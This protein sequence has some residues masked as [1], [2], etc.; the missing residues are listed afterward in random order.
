MTP[1]E[2]Q[3]QHDRQIA[4]IRKLLRV[5]KSLVIDT[6]KDMRELIAV[7]KR[8]EQ[9]LE[10]LIHTMRRGANGHTRRKVDLQ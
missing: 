5:R 7:H 3:D 4:A 6:R 8:T 2:R 10:A 1:R 9:K